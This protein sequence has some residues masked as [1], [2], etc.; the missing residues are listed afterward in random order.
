VL[1]LKIRG[2]AYRAI[3]KYEEAFADFNKLLEI[4][5]KD[6]FGL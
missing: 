6:A 5:P 2:A 3:E 1:V 4:N